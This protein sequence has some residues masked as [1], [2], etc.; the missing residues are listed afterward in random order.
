MQEDPDASKDLPP[1]MVA[2]QVTYGLGNMLL[3]SFRC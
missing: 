1:V 2:E 3:I